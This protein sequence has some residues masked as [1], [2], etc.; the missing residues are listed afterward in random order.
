M[1]NRKL[2][3]IIFFLP[4]FLFASVK[5]EIINFYK[6][7]YPK[8]IIKQ[9]K[10]IPSPPK[11]Y[12]NL[13]I[14]FS[15]NT[16]SGDIRID[17]HY[18]FVRIKAYLPVYIATDIIKNNR[19]VYNHITKKILLFRYF[20]SKPLFKINKKLVASK[21][22]SKNAVI[23]ENNT[24]IAPDI[25][26]GDIVTVIISS[27]DI[28]IFSKGKALQDGNIGDIIKIRFR[29]KTQNAKVIQKGTVLIK[30]NE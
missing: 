25:F 27:K 21:I 11:K 18:Y 20:Y 16:I 17:S 6:K 8:I 26:K 9:I 3:I 23:T 7:S 29:K 1:E 30:G 5:Q 4:I 19:P 28:S 15:P 2:K 12:K 14:L 22:I 13:K 24:K 10:I